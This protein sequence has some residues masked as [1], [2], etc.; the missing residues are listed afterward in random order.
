MS[1]PTEAQ[2][3]EYRWRAMRGDSVLQWQGDYTDAETA[4]SVGDSYVEWRAAYGNN[5]GVTVHVDRRLIVH[6]PDWEPVE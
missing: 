6:Q 1:N 2:I 4:R 3:Y 5:D